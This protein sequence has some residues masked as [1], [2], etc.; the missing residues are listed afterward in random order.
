LARSVGFRESAAVEFGTLPKAEQR[1]LRDLLKRIAA[2][3]PDIPIDL[4][5]ERVRGTETLWRIA[6]GEYRC[7]FRIERDRLVVFAVGL[8][9]GFYLRFE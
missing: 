5:V 3:F 9:R 7:V 4:D 6:F 8:R 2:S 1:S